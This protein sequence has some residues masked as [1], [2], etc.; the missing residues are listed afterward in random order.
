LEDYKN[1]F[2]E[3]ENENIIEGDPKDKISAE[4]GKVHYLPH[5]PV[6]RED[7]ETNKVLPV[8]DTSCGVNGPS[9]HKCLCSGPK[10]LSKYRVCQKTPPILKC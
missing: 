5:L 1:I 6:I 10:L 8:F 9:L 7:K 3:Y 4:V 2:P